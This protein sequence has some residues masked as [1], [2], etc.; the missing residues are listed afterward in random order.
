MTASRIVNRQC[1]LCEAHCGVRVHV[2]GD[3]V[4]RIE[5]DPEDVM[6]KGYICPKGTTLWDLHRDPERLR[7]RAATVGPPLRPLPRLLSSPSAVRCPRRLPFH[8]RATVSFASAVAPAAGAAFETV[9]ALTHAGGDPP[10]LALSPHC[11][12]ALCA[13][14]FRGCRLVLDLGN[15]RVAVVQE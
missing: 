15:D 14:L 5:G 6:S 13:D 9:R 10:D 3:A 7:R 4:T 11:D 1:Q 8:R 12:G 2:D